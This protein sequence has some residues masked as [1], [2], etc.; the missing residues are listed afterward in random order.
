MTWTGDGYLAN[1]AIYNYQNFR[2]VADPGWALSWDWTAG[3][4]IWTMSG[5]EPTTQGDCGLRGLPSP[6]GSVPLSCEPSPII[7]DLLPEM[8]PGGAVNCCRG[9]VLSAW[10][11]NETLA[12]T[13]FTL[14]VGNASNTPYDLKGPQNFSIGIPG[15]LCTPAI[16]VAST[17][18]TLDTR[19]F[20]QAQATWVVSCA[21]SQRDDAAPAQCCVSYSSFYNHTIVPCTKCACACGNYSKSADVCVQDG[22]PYL[23]QTGRGGTLTDDPN[24]MSCSPDGCPVGI[25][26]HLKVNYKEYW[27]A[28]V[29]ITNR[30]MHI[31][32]TDWTLALEH[33]AFTNFT[34]VFSWQYRAVQPYGVNNTALFWGRPGYNEILMPGNTSAGNVQSEMLF[35]KDDAFSLAD[36]WGFPRRIVFNGH[37]C[38]L[39]EEF[40]TLPSG[41]FR[42][43]PP[44]LLA[45]GAA[46]AALALLFAL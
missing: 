34:Q 22:A 29:T 35:A 6:G 40:P 16:T 25:H 18:F 13:N 23:V 11:Q 37:E 30:N 9:G 33:P 4:L 31:N 45:L 2:Q 27:R 5:A 46:T 39:P 19:Y 32:Y 42:L 7:V 38:I 28:K 43:P 8:A 1:V 14:K 36:G 44:L 26:Y 17:N 20:T 21:Y 12:M 3:E 15:F 10:A 24:S 41:A